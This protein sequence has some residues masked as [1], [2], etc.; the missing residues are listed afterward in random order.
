MEQY[1][2]EAIESIL[3]QTFSDFEFIIIDDESTD[4]TWEL[5]QSY[6]DER[7]IAIRN[8]ENLGNY[9]SRNRGMK[10]ARGKYIAVM[11]SDDVAM[12]ERLEKQYSHLEENCNIIARS[13][14]SI[15][16]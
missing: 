4:K 7:I 14:K 6:R 10:M 3:T 13:H 15:Y 5:I 12:P 9:P 1:V 8:H 2:G 16:K 11:D